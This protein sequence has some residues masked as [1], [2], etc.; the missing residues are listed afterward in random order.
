MKQ[1]VNTHANYRFPFQNHFGLWKILDSLLTLN[2]QS[3]F[4]QNHAGAYFTE[5]G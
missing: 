4:T 5:M 3:V 1:Y 2:I